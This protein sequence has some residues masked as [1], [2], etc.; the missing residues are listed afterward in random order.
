MNSGTQ[1]FET[2]RRLPAQA[3]DKPQAIPPVEFLSNAEKHP[4]YQLR[5]SL[6][7]LGETLEPNAG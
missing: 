6:L 4:Q 1:S 7:Q 5:L 2:E 3:R